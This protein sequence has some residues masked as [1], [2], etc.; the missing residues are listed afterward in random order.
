MGWD[1]AH[2][3]WL[4]RDFRLLSSMQFFLSLSLPS[5]RHCVGIDMECL[6]KIDTALNEDELFLEINLIF[7]FF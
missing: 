5:F 6:M 1:S 7:S 3:C 2:Y 4:I